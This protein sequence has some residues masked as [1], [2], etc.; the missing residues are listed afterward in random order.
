MLL[1][2]RPSLR[3]SARPAVTH[4]PFANFQRQLSAGTKSSRKEYMELG[5]RPDTLIFSTGNIRLHEQNTFN[6]WHN[7][8]IWDSSCQSAIII[9]TSPKLLFCYSPFNII[10]DFLIQIS[11]FLRSELKFLKPLVQSS[12]GLLVKKRTQS[13][14]AVYCIHWA[15]LHVVVL[16][17]TLRRKYTLHSDIL[18]LPNFMFCTTIFF[19]F[20]FN[21]MSRGGRGPLFT[22]APWL[23][24][25]MAWDTGPVHAETAGQR[26]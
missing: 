19:T 2:P 5:S 23:Q 7:Q 11:K 13:E 3:L 10:K 12:Y 16:H 6:H 24:K 21:T 26:E 8:H 1:W 25:T 14:A 4:S 18:I 17:F 22:F 9:T 20:D 15:M